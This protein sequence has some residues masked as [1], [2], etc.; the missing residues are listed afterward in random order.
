VNEI[1]AKKSKTGSRLLLCLF[2][3]NVY[4]SNL[5]LPPW[6]VAKI[7][8]SKNCLPF[9]NVQPSVR[10]PTHPPFKM[11]LRHSLQLLI[12]TGKRLSWFHLYCSASDSSFT[13]KT[14]KVLY[15]LLQGT[16]TEREGSVLRTLSLR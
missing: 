3:Y 4:G 2:K 10:E 16:L 6:Q 13:L 11:T 1:L 14:P 9:L 15:R 12:A 7:I 5:V 8:S